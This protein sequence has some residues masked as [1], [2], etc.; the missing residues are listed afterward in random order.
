VFLYTAGLIGGRNRGRLPFFEIEIENQ[1]FTKE[2]NEGGTLTSR[3]ILRAHVSGADRGV[4][5]DDSQTILL[6]ALKAIRNQSAGY[7]NVGEDSIGPLTAGP[8][9]FQR[10]AILTIDH[11]WDKTSYETA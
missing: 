1:D 9:G 8:W 6:F 4:G 2:T 10:D 11:S 3:V 7:F 5:A